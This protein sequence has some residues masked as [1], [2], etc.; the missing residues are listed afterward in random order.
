MSDPANIPAPAGEEYP[1]ETEGSE[2]ARQ[3]R[4]SLNHLSDEE[5]DKHLA[6]ALA[7]VYGEHAI[8]QESGPGH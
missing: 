2:A 1:R 5:L 7:I 3:A 4:E 8:E 6:A